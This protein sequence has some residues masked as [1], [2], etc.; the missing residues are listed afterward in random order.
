MKMNI[1]NSKFI[2]ANLGRVSSV[3][4]TSFFLKNWPLIL[5]NASIIFLFLSPKV[6]KQ[7]MFFF[8]VSRIILLL[9][10]E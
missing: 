7:F 6:P 3:V 1:K 5:L 4:L 10:I 9:S 2:F 8:Q